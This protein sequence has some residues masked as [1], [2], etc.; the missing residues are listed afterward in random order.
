MTRAKGAKGGRRPVG[1][2]RGTVATS[3]QSPGIRETGEGATTS[4]VAGAPPAPIDLRSIPISRIVPSKTNPRRRIDP[5]KQSELTESIRRLGVLQPIIVRPVDHGNFEIVGGYCRFC[6]AKEADLAEIPANVRKL[7]DLEALEVQMI[8]NIQRSDLH[9]IEEAQG[10]QALMKHGYDAARIAEKVGRSV[11]YVYDRVKLMHL[12]DRGRELFL[13]GVLTPGHAILLARIGEKD[14]KRALELGQCV[15]EEN[16]LFDPTEGPM[17]RAS[18]PKHLRPVSVRELQAWIDKYVRFSTDQVDPM[19][20][21]HTA[22][23]VAAAREKNRKVVPVTFLSYIPDEARDGRTFF[24]QSWKRADGQHLSKKCEHSVMGFVAVGPRRGESFDVCVNKDKCSVHW[25]DKIRARKK[26]ATA[27]STAAPG[28]ANGKPAK[29]ADPKREVALENAREQANEQIDALVLK[30]VGE[31]KP[32]EALRLLACHS[33]DVSD[34]MSSVKARGSVE[35]WCKKAK[36]AELQ[37]ALIYE[38]VS[39]GEADEVAKTLGIDA[40]KIR[41]EHETRA[42]AS[43]KLDG[44]VRGVCGVC[45]CTENKACPGGCAWTDKTKTLCTLCGPKVKGERTSKASAKKKRSGR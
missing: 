12:G 30:G 31:L 14:Q 39:Y 28:R 36:P 23:D 32:I 19:L 4:P 29:Q 15:H 34:Y 16:L 1:V 41:K 3:E 9:P 24:P 6:A 38:Q 42:L 27:G 45:G 17:S 26:R 7:G 40:T 8:E 21:P 10:Y 18:R 20:F 25:A 2:R 11:A 35:E 44:T 43:L 37:R 13:D 22:L 5:K 33:R